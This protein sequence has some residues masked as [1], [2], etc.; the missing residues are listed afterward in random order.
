[1]KKLLGI[2]R[3]TT[4]RPNG[5]VIRRENIPAH[6]ITE[7]GLIVFGDIKIGPKATERK[8]LQ[9]LISYANKKNFQLNLCKVYKKK[10]SGKPEPRS[11]HFRGFRKKHAMI[12]T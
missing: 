7:T 5:S 2:I 4:K 9:A 11:K 12:V 1:M 6:F 10:N 8:A 3:F